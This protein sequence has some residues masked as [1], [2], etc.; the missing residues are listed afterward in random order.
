MEENQTPIQIM[1]FGV[2]SG[3]GYAMSPFFAHGLRL[4]RET[5]I[6]SQEEVVLA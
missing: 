3:D 5:F 4:Y 1:V 6:K 2:V